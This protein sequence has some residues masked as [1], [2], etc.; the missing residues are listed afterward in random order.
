[1]GSW[2]E[3]IFHGVEVSC[4]CG[5][6]EVLVY[7]HLNIQPSISFKALRCAIVSYLTTKSAVAVACRR[8]GMLI[9]DT[10]TGSSPQH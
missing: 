6:L 5:D 1:M 9:R 3:D 2:D 4:R 10:D 7:I 8:L